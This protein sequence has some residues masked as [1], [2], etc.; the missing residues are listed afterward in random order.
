MF[1]EKTVFILGAG[2]SWHYGYPT[3]ADLIKNVIKFAD[4]LVQKLQGNPYSIQGIDI[5]DVSKY[6][7]LELID[8]C[9]KIAERLKQTN[10][11]VIDYFLEQNADLRRI[12]KFLIAWVLIEDEVFYHGNLQNGMDRNKNIGGHQGFE[13]QDWY[14]FIAYKLLS[15]LDIRNPSELSDKNNVSFITFNYDVSLEHR[16]YKALNQV[17]FLQS[18]SNSVKRFMEQEDRFI[19][20]YGQIRPVSEVLNVPVL[21][22][23]GHDW[24]NKK[25]DILN[26]ASKAAE[27]IRIIPELKNGN[28]SVLDL[29]KS[30]IA[31]AENVY[32]LGYGFDP[33]NN[34]RIGLEQLSRASRKN[35]EIYF[36]NYGDKDSINKRVNRLWGLGNGE[37][38][39]SHDIAYYRGGPNYISHLTRK[40][41]DANS[42][43]R[44]TQ[45][46]YTALESDFDFL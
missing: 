4:D 40:R 16:L 19:H 37:N 17:N 21:N 9:K 35:K 3:G 10:A 42:Y 27:N 45:D 14:R 44:S 20:V 30:K 12:G 33:Q 32:I 11:L 18:D 8:D 26:A 38:I 46:V 31:E 5:L 34:G 7:R 1:E 25:M 22:E 13:R 39:E 29:A 23:R 2:A 15:D 41:D 36:T 43:D 6:P 28:V 24:Y